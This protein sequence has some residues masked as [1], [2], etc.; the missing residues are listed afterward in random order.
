MMLFIEILTPIQKSMELTMRAAYQQQKGCRR[1]QLYFAD[2]ALVI[3]RECP[4][5][6][7][8][9]VRLISFHM[10]DA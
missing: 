2:S 7:I 4:F 10:A 6:E 8:D 3:E 5:P 9:D 1:W